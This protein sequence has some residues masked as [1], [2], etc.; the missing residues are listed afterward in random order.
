MFESH[1][2]PDP[3]TAHAFQDIDGLRKQ[4]MD[5]R[6]GFG[7]VQLAISW[8]E[9]VIV[10]HGFAQMR[11]DSEKGL[12]VADIELEKRIEPVRSLFVA[13]TLCDY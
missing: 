11:F 8:A 3:A 10:V 13:D 7:V 2:S 5:C 6:I 12:T 9:D 4:G 1:V